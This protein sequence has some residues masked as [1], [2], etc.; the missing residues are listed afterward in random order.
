MKLV[1][2]FDYSAIFEFA[3]IWYS[4]IEP[5]QAKRWRV[6]PLPRPLQV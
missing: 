1:K 2:Y 3:V 4:D 5:G 6:V